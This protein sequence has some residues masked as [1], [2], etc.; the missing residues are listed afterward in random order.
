METLI[1][2]TPITIM[3]TCSYDF[4]YDSDFESAASENS[5]KTFKYF[6][7]ETILQERT[8]VSAV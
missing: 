6:R 7:E 4:A 5:F 3:I 8:K 1:L 2:Q